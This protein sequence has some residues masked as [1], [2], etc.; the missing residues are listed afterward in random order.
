LY[1]LLNLVK[2]KFFA[3]KMENYIIGHF[4]DE[5]ASGFLT[6]NIE[7][8]RDYFIYDPNCYVVKRVDECRYF[9]QS[10]KKAIHSPKK[11]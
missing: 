4:E 10:N 7:E 1:S 3:E 2:K 11:Q 5:E 6:E 9:L 8:R